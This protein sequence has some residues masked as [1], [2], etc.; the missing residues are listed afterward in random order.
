MALQKI[1]LTNRLFWRLISI[2]KNEK[3]IKSSDSRVHFIFLNNQNKNI[4]NVTS[5]NYRIKLRSTLIKPTL[6]VMA[7][8]DISQCG[9]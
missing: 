1:E 8:K 7:K 3:K 9:T 2:S 6:F 4:V 5:A